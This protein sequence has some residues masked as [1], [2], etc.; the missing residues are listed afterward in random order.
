M[1]ATDV[2]QRGLDVK[3]V[4]WVINYDMPNNI[5]D[6]IHRIGRTGRA[7]ATGT[8]VTY[9][10]YDYYAP[11]KVRMAQG[12]ISAMRKV[13]QT[14]PEKLQEIASAGGKVAG[15]RSGGGR[16]SGRSHSYRSDYL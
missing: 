5:E 9:F 16:G 1:V 2:A 14:P 4:K 11:E 3:N 15:G 7:G 10:H 12:I 13:G 6:Y 8:S